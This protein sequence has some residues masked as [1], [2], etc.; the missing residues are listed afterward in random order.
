LDAIL[1]ATDRITSVGRWFKITL[2]ILDARA[3]AVGAPR[4]AVADVLED[5]AE[6]VLENQSG[7]AVDGLLQNGN[8]TD[9]QQT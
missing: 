9:S 2:V 7:K 8:L 6:K 4:Q 5:F 3:D 1:A